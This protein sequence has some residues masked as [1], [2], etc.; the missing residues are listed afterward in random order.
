MKQPKVSFVI[1]AYNQQKYIKL[2]VR[3]ALNQTYSPLEIIIS[4]DC[5]N[6]LTYP[7]IESLTSAYKGPH[8]IKLNR[9]SSNLG[10]ASNMNKAMALATGD[11]TIVSAGDDIS[12]INRTQ[13]SMDIFAK[14][15]ECSSV[16][17]SAQLIDS[18]GRASDYRKVTSDEKL[19]VKNID[20]FIA[21]E[22]TT[23]GAGRAIVNN[24]YEN[25]GP[26]E[27]LCPTEDTPFMLRSLLV[28]NVILS[29]DIG[30]MY[31]V[32]DSN[33]SSQDSIAK[34][35]LINLLSQY[36]TDILKAAR[37]R[38]IP[39]IKIGFL[40]AYCHYYIF[41]RRLIG[42]KL[43]STSFVS[44]LISRVCL[45]LVRLAWMFA[46]CVYRLTN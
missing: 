34:M 37:L 13:L 12:L 36:K 22:W 33:L 10:L 23:F 45:F 16:I 26:L 31:R 17:L 14:Y 4:D 39:R 28:G 6:D 21:G 11:Y 3:G 38:C 41:N 20:D 5:S 1:L 19:V 30:L 44:S 40:W 15:P 43:N 29:S 18:K 24:V 35:N 32:H 7:I 8:E 2:S 42:L 9:N 27:P 46:R 25:F